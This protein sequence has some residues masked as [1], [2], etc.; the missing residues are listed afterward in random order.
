MSQFSNPAFKRDS[1]TAWLRPLSYT[2]GVFPDVLGLFAQ[3]RPDNAT[4]LAKE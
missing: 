4:V 1:A 2:L 3:L